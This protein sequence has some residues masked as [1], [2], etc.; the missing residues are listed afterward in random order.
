MPPEPLLPFVRLR[1]LAALSS[2]S[3]RMR[4]ATWL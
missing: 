3:D 2:T 4:S 1:S